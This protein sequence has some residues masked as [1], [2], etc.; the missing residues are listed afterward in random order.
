[1]MTDIAQLRDLQREYIEKRNYWN[2][3]IRQ[4]SNDLSNCSPGPSVLAECR[5][6]ADE[7]IANAAAEQKR[8]DA[9]QVKLD[10]AIGLKT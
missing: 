4:Q 6:Q 5:K 10:E 1:M 3:R 9:I 2:M 7:W 8:I